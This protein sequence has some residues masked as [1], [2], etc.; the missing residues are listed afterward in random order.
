MEIN[1][2]KK[3]VSTDEFHGRSGKY[4]LCNTV[5]KIISFAIIQ[6]LVKLDY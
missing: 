5:S 2:R 4:Q 6:N 3:V 1:V